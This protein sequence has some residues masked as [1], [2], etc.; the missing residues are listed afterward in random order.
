MGV[1]FIYAKIMLFRDFV[2]TG[3]SPPFLVD[4]QPLQLVSTE[5]RMYLTYVVVVYWANSATAS[6]SILSRKQ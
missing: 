5:I 2:R 3:G 4:I 1:S 6:K